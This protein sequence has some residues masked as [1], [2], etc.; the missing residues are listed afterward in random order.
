MAEKLVA[1]DGKYLVVED[2]TT[3]SKGGLHI[4]GELM[5]VHG[6]G[7]VVSAGKG[8]VNE[9]TGGL[10]EPR[11]SVGDRVCFIK[12]SQ[13]VVDHGGAKHF[14]LTDHEIV[15]TLEEE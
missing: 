15:A 13:M 5:T 9:F 6:Y 3:T 14:V 12:H 11:L 10:I 8:R 7:K 2:D 1:H 4:P